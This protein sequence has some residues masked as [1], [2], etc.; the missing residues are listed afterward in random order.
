MNTHKDAQKR[1]S[2]KLFFSALLPALAIVLGLL[3]WKHAAGEVPQV[4]FYL[5]YGLVVLCALI[6]LFA[7]AKFYIAHL[8]GR[9]DAT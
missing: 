2:L 8:G 7:V 6:C 4:L 3:A 5:A 1:A 9:A